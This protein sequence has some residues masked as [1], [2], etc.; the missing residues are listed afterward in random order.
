MTI[1]PPVIPGIGPFPGH[2]GPFTNITPFTYRSGE[3][4]LEYVERLRTYVVNDIAPYVDSARAELVDEFVAKVTQV[5]DDTNAALVAQANQVDQALDSQAESVNNALTVQSQENASALAEMT[6]FVNNA[7]FTIINE[8]IEVSDPVI[9]GVLEN[10]TSNSRLLIDSMVVPLKNARRAVRPLYPAT[11]PLPSLSGPVRSF[12]RGAYVDALAKVLNDVSTTTGSNVITSASAA[13]TS[14]DIGK[15]IIGPGLPAAGTT[16]ASVSNGTTANM[17]NTASATATNVTLY[18]ERALTKLPYDT[19]QVT[20]Y[21]MIPE[22]RTQ[23]SRL[24]QINRSS[25]DGSGAQC[26][27]EFDVVVTGDSQ[28]FS[29]NYVRSSSNSPRVWLFVNGIPASRRCDILPNGSSN[30][31]WSYGVTSLPTGRS[32]IRLV[33]EGMDFG[34]ISTTSGVVVSAPPKVA[35]VGA[36][37]MDSWG[38]GAGP[39]TLHST[40]VYLSLLLGAEIYINAQ[41][42][43]SYANNGGGG[44]KSIYGDN[45]RLART[46]SIPNLEFIVLWG[47]VN[48][49]ALNKTTVKDNAI[50]VINNLIAN[51]SAKIIVVGPQNS[52]TEPSANAIANRD[53]VALA[54]ATVN[55]ARVR[56]VDPIGEAWLTGTGSTTSK[57]NNGLLDYLIDGSID[58]HPT[59]EGHEMTARYI[60]TAV[61][62]SLEN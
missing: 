40:P 10:S 17:A 52:G 2:G 34:G 12:N 23:G 54:V 55:N 53:A 27:I 43:T 28:G 51:T 18:L 57:Q 8:T 26:I 48:D 47:S 24:Y 25:N 41:G 60:A 11:V 22:T 35:P 44:N 33:I 59:P 15:F 21:G 61:I 16:I 3:A 7:V 45:A 14:D 49:T 58:N 37:I 31:T 29:L 4:L 13:F 6:E 46:T 9:L 62:A 50:A 5:I 56:F 32:R 20:R 38:R 30:A 36:A 19:A 39:Y 1:T 42:G